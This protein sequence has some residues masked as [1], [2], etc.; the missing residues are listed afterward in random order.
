MLSA[1]GEDPVENIENLPPSGNMALSVL[2]STSRDFQEEGHWF[3]AEDDYPLSPN[4]DG[5][6]VIPDSI[7]SLT[8]PD[9]NVVE[10]RPR[11]YNLGSK[12]FH[13]DAPLSCSVILHLEWGELPSV[14]R[15]YITAL[16]IERFV[17]GIPGVEAV[18]QARARNLLRAKAAF[19]KAA[20][21]NGGLNLLN[22]T[23]IQNLIRRN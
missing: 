11:L 19:D 14:A 20:I 3:N 9:M 18:S 13:F 8:S 23:T 1:I 6:I 5:E 2:R 15:R 7:I 22:N 12:S 17:D 16:A 10:R 4:D 21:R